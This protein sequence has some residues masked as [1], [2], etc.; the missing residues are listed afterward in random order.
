MLSLTTSQPVPDEVLLDALRIRCSPA[1]GAMQLANALGG[2]SD[3]GG[4]W[5]ILRQHPPLAIVMEVLDRQL[6]VDGLTASCSETP[7]TESWV[8]IACLELTFGPVRPRCRDC[9]VLLETHADRSC[10]SAQRR[11][12]SLG[13][14]Q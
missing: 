5:P 4:P 1:F 13:R 8:W 3:D 6:S 10:G 7:V 12:R 14:R 2:V 11:A 9:G